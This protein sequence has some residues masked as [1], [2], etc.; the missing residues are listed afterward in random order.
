MLVGVGEPKPQPHVFASGP[1]P[2]MFLSLSSFFVLDQ[3]F[4]TLFDQVDFCLGRRDVRAA[5]IA[6]SNSRQPRGQ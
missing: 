6:A 1:W 4:Q 2:Q 3:I 5:E